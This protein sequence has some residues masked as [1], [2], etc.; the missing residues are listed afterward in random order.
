MA[1]NLSPQEEQQK[2]AVMS[3]LAR[4]VMIATPEHRKEVLQLLDQEVIT[5]LLS[6]M[7][8]HLP[9]ESRQQALTVV[10]HI[11]QT[12]T[13]EN[14]DQLW[15]YISDE[16]GLK[17]PRNA[18]CEGHCSP[19]DF[20]SDAF[21]ERGL[22]DKL[23]IGNRG[24]GKTQLSGMLHGINAK[25]K[26]KI[27]AVSAG[28]IENQAKKC[29]EYFR[30]TVMLWPDFYSKKDVKIRESNFPNG[31]KVEVVIGTM[32]GVNSPHPNVAHLDEIELLRP[33]VF[34]ESANMAQGKTVIIDGEEVMYRAQNWLTS[35]W[36]KPRGLVTKLFD[37]IAEAARLGR[38]APYQVYRWCV[39]ETTQPCEHDCS[40]CPFSDHIKGKW[41]DGSPR[42]FEQ[43]CKKGSRFE[44]EGRLKHSD[45][46][47]PLEDTINKFMRLGRRVWEA[48][49][50]SKRPTAEGLVYEV[51]DEDIHGL[52]MWKPDPELGPVDIGLDFGG[53]NPFAAVFTQT[54]NVGVTFD[55]KKIPEGAVVQFDEI[56]ETGIGNIT[57][58]LM[59]NRKILQWDVQCP[60]FIDN[61]VAFYRDPAA[62]SAAIDLKQLSNHG[63][64]D[65]EYRSI[66]TIARGRVEVDQSIA[67]VAEQVDEGY[68]Y[69][70]T[71]RC[72]E[73]LN[74]FLSYEYP[75]GK[76]AGQPIKEND[77]AMDALRYRF[78]NV[79]LGRGRTGE[80]GQRAGYGSAA[81]DGSSTPRAQSRHHVGP[82]GSKGLAKRTGI[83]IHGV[84]QEPAKGA[85]VEQAE[86]ASP[87]VSHTVRL[88]R[89]FG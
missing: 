84:S 38:R 89:P 32:S 59:I 55:G 48:Q 21:F 8:Q 43:V 6:Y 9:P 71:E 73:T 16:I 35:S 62:K 3:Q 36:K 49:Q 17:I 14:D 41:E 52:T 15:Q 64:G 72:P 50:E 28:A 70:D 46:F 20:V 29:Y 47:I 22:L 68:F 1:D 31:S 13:P 65:P 83:W 58:G 86:V 27:E 18:V 80:P 74:E 51:F 39:F 7:M 33:G 66:P 2:A 12:W 81:G 5:E 24:S 37:E 77:H 87:R 11:R 23:I 79:K 85:R 53:K 25:L 57:F 78:W 69:L 45:G 34:E 10:K 40:A 26:P 75:E 60:G 44:D 56:Y 19:Y 88:R 67:Y 63:N 30:K 54:L 42:S 4:R 61:L 82:G 76:N